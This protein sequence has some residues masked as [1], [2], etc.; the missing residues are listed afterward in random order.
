M[1]QASR[2]LVTF[3]ALTACVAAQ[4]TSIP[5]ITV[6][7][8]VAT[9]PLQN[10]TDS[11]LPAFA[12]TLF[13]PGATSLR[14]ELA[15]VTLGT[16]EDAVVFRDPL[17]GDV[18]R[19]T[20]GMLKRWKNWTGWFNGASVEMIVSV[21]PG[22]VAAVSVAS[23]LT[24]P[25]IGIDGNQ[26][27][28]GSE[29]RVLSN[30]QASCRLLGNG[31]LCSGA[32]VDNWPYCVSAGHC[33]AP[34]PGALVVAEFS[35]PPSSSSGAIVH[36]PIADQYPIDESS[37]EF[38]DGGAGADWS[39]FRL[40]PNS[41]GESAFLRQ[42]TAFVPATSLPF[43]GTSVVRM[44]GFGTHPTPALDHSTHT[45]TGI[46]IVTIGDRITH[47]VDLDNGD[48]GG[49]LTN[50]ATGELIGVNTHGG[51][52]T[53]IGAN[54]ATSI[55]RPAFVTARNNASACGH[56]SLTN[57]VSATQLTCEPREVSIV[58]STSAWNVIAV[59]DSNDDYDI[60]IEGVS[61]SFNGTACDF[62]VSNGNNAPVSAPVNAWVEGIGSVSSGDV[63]FRIA[64]T[65][66]VGTL[67][68]I[69]WGSNQ[70]VEIK[71]F[72]ITTAGNYDVTV[73]G[74]DGYNWRVYRPG[75]NSNWRSRSSADFSGAV[76]GGTLNGLAL[77]AGT[78][79]LVIFKNG[80]PGVGD[81]AA[82]TAVIAPST[83]SIALTSTP[84][85]VTNDAQDFTVTP[86]AGEWNAVSVSSNSN[87][88][89]AIG[90]GYDNQGSNLN[91]FAIAN[92]HDG[93]IAPTAGVMVRAAG[94]DPGTAQHMFS[95][96]ISVN[97][98]LATTLVAGRVIRL[99]EFNVTTAGTYDIGITGGELDPRMEWRLYAP[100]GTSR[101]RNR[102]D[103]IAA[104]DVGED[105][106]TA[107]S[108]STGW[109][110]I[111]V[112]RDDGPP[113]ATIG[114]NVHVYAATAVDALTVG[115]NNTVTVDDQMFSVSSP[116]ATWTAVGCTSVGTTNVNVY[117]GSGESNFATGGTTDFVI[118]NGNAGTIPDYRGIVVRLSG[119]DA[120]EVERATVTSLTPGTTLND[121]YAS[122]QV[123]EVYEF[124]V[125]I[126][127]SFDV[128]TTG[129]SS[130]GWSLFE[131]GT[132]GAWRRRS[133]DVISGL[134]GAASVV[135][136][137]TQTGRHALVV[138][139]SGATGATAAVSLLLTPHNL[140]PTLTS[141]APTQATSGAAAFTLSATGSGFV[142]G[143]KVRWN[144]VDLTTTFVSATQLTASVPAANVASA[145]TASV[146]VFNPA[147][148]GG[149]SAAQTFTI[150]NPVPTLASLSPSSA[151]SLGSAFTL[152]VNGTNFRSGSVVRWN[153]AARTTTFVST[154]QLTASIPATDIQ[155]AGTAT[156]TVFNASP[157]GGVSGN[158]T[159]TITNP[160][161]TTSALS[162]S[163]ATSLGAAFTLVVTGTG[164]RSTSVVNWNG[165]P[166][167]TTFVS[168]TSLTAA[169][170]AA[171]IA[172]AGTA[173]ITVSSPAPGGGNS[174]AQTF[175]INNPAPT[176]SLISPSTRLAGSPS[177]TLNV[178]GTNFRNGSTIRW[179]GAPRATTFTS[180]S[181][182][183]ATIS[184]A[185]VA[186]AGT[187]TVTVST[188][189]P[190]GGTSAG[191]SFTITNPVPALSSVTPNVLLT[192]SGTTTVTVAG[193]GFNSQSSVR[194]NGSTAGVTTTLVSA[195][196]LSVSVSASLLAAPGSATVTVLNPPPSGGVTSGAVV[197]IVGPRLSGVL[198]TALLAPLTAGGPSVNV[199]LLSPTGVSAAATVFHVNGV[200]VTASFA[201]LPA[202]V[203]I[204]IPSSIPQM[205]QVGGVTITAKNFGVW[206]SNA[207]PLEIEDRNNQG[208]IEQNPVAPS[209]GQA[210]A[211]MVERCIPVAPFIL[212]ADFTNPP[213]LAGWPDGVSN[214]VLGVNPF[215]ANAVLDG[216]G[217][218]GPANPLA[219]FS[220]DPVLPALGTFALPGLIQPNPPLGISISLQAVYPDPTL[221]AGFRLTH[222]RRQF[223]M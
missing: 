50:E 213:P 112:F 57:N 151:T 218:F 71:E 204:T 188:P 2:S 46:Y 32:L 223:A 155:T 70:L 40:H 87:W 115:E 5:M 177:F 22:S 89:L 136:T 6:R 3:L 33:A 99:Y 145:G 165:A 194:W 185:D 178:Q 77:T 187:V 173:S 14:V 179:N 166:L 86:V 108:L 91:A 7:Y 1:S 127:R 59:S 60:S 168:T 171:N 66:N 139:R 67:N 211:L 138:Y 84:T 15:D 110:C 37:I 9:G 189:S 38:E 102:S 123:L 42:G 72:S 212:F 75:T 96:T 56:T 128:V 120:Y 31:T 215:P 4:G 113:A 10:L 220:P 147:P 92:G 207:I 18:Q 217:V 152:T 98:T 62:L 35:V 68:V 129:P 157:G 90:G 12:T 210:F 11:P 8:P 176:V 133:D 119:T 199:T 142:S 83:T 164:F 114:F 118:A 28:C 200:P 161:P 49:P 55:F 79:A 29:D 154:T 93:A 111:A 149:T 160:V 103:Y 26:G 106:L 141:I 16:D 153:G 125:P 193:S 169:V 174:A 146:V 181:A 190:G 183:S 94:T 65:I 97:S 17:S 132:N 162:P 105:F 170:P 208:T 23:V 76:N 61:S 25:A 39:V 78:H 156:V 53:A 58:P 63:Q 219:V 44:R 182:L 51:C 196:S 222:A 41:N 36:P 13:V 54:S 205:Q 95:T 21:A 175:T 100:T 144:G 206:T 69:P 27:I 80:E 20:R 45:G 167:G 221:P 186:N 216:L 191:V 34:F 104:G 148:G 159:F 88:D 163:S 202:S 64:G 135:Y 209:P 131:P 73:A 81:P 74:A 30:S 203:Q 24:I 180:V 121:S 47:L 130:F 52:N 143:A 109:H 122:N 214:L 150:N 126:L 192:G 117:L 140:V 197:N 85:T 101:W 116:P 19:M 48:S 184:A 82:F 134:I 198:P 172:T 124:D 107:F 43:P 195:T 137:P 158:A 201:G